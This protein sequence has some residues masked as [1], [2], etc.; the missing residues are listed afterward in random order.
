MYANLAGLQ[1]VWRGVAASQFS[2]AAEQW[3]SAQQQMEV[4]LEAIQQSLTQASSVYSDAENQAIRL[5]S[6]S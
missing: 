4:S 3:R 6:A 5:F 2:E 1:D